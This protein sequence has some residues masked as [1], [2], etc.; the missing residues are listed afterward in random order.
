MRLVLLLVVLTL[1]SLSPVLLVDSILA[2][3]PSS[4][5][6]YDGESISLYG[7]NNGP[8]VYALGMSVSGFGVEAVATQGRGLVSVFTQF[9]NS[10]VWLIVCLAIILII[11]IVASILSSSVYDAVKASVF[12]ITAVSVLGVYFLHR[13]LKPLL[14][15]LSLRTVVVDDAVATLS[16]VIIAGTVVNIIAVAV[17]SG[18]LTHLVL[19]LKPPSAPAKPTRPQALEKPVETG[20]GGARR[21]K[22]PPLGTPPLCPN[23]GSKLVWK[24]EESRYYCEKCQVYPEDVCFSI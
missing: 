23:C 13:D 5:I 6:R 9:F 12:S 19:T 10:G 7:L 8:W 1:L 2:M 18:V 3:L 15:G 24:P 14:Y 21:G 16:L 17:L 11:S 22:A 4:S 20:T